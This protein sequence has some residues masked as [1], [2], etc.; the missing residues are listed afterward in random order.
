[1]DPDLGSDVAL[2]PSARLDLHATREWKLGGALSRL[3]TTVALDNLT[4]QAVF[5]QCGLPQPGRLLRLQIRI[6]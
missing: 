2:D 3:Q 5:D 4:D 6:G 1:V